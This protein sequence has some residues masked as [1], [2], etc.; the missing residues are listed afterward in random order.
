[1]TVPQFTQHHF[2]RGSTRLVLGPNGLYVSQGPRRGAARLETE[3]PYEELLPITLEY[4]EPKPVRVRPFVIPAW[5]IAQ[6]ALHLTKN[7]DDA[8]AILVGGLSFLLGLAAVVLVRRYRGRR[9][10]L[11]TNR[12]HLAFHDSSRHRAALS[13]FVDAMQLRAHAYLREEYAAVNPLGHIE[14]QLHRLHWLRQLKVLSEQ[15]YRTL[16]TRLTGRLS[17]D[18]IKLMG[19]DLETPYLN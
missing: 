14:L 5:L 10:L 7:S 16:S 6:A 19:Q 8:A 1:M 3:I 2:L 15:E 4:Q 12:I 18:S 11:T 9:V 17:Q 13:T